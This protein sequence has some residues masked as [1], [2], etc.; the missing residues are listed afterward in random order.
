MQMI[1]NGEYRDASSGKTFENINPY[2]GELVCNV[3]S[4]TAEDFE[5][6]ARLRDKEVEEKNN[7]EIQKEEWRNKNIKEK[8]N[9]TKNDIREVI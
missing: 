7:L 2:T 3:A 6:A 4:G 9:L 5:E 1:I 8:V